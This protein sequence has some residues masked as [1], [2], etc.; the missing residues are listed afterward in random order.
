MTTKQ[1]FVRF[2]QFLLLSVLFF[3]FFTLGNLVPAPPLPPIP[4]DQQW[5]TLP[6][7]GLVCLVDT[8]LIMLVILRAS[9]RGWRLMLGV[10]VAF[11]GVTTFMSQIET[12]WFGP[13]LGIGREMLPSLFLGMV[14]VSFIFVPLA[15]WILGKARPWNTVSE[16]AVAGNAR[17]RMPAGTWAWKLAVIA[18]AYL[19]F[20][21]GFGYI[22]AWQNPALREMYGSGANQQVFNF[23]LLIPFQLLRGVLWAL[24]ALPIIAMDRGPRWQ[25]AVVVGLWL[26]LPMNIVHAVPNPFM[27]DPSV[28][29][30]HFIETSASN[31]LFGVLITLLLL[32]QARRAVQ[33]QAT[34]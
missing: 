28:R 25:T 32:W 15:V 5:A 23:W 18:V 9:W 8:A 34:N 10:A 4:A 16:E 33:V 3:V 11:Y 14:P 21:F 13:S 1:L 2:G 22:V 26:A 29:L 17:L 30:S 19:F 24:F 20:Y 31:F 27:P 7:V 6:A 12:A